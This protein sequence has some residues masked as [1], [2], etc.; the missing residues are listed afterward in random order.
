MGYSSQIWYAPVTGSASPVHRVTRSRPS[1]LRSKAAG[2]SP[3]LLA[4]G[5]IVYAAYSTLPVQNAADTT[6]T[7]YE[8]VNAVVI[9]RTDGLRTHSVDDETLQ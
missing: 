4:V 8:R 9:R 6:W 1:T 7:T 3:P 5:T 2:G